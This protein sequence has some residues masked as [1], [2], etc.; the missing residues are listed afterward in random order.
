M[1]LPIEKLIVA[2]NVN[3]ILHRCLAN[4][5]YRKQDLVPTISPS[6]DIMVSSN[7]E[8][9]LFDLHDRDSGKINNLMD[10]FAQ[11]GM[12]LEAPAMKH[13]R[14]IFTSCRVDDQ[15]TLAQVASTY[16]DSAYL[17]D[18]H[19][20]IGVAAAN[21]LKLNAAT[22]MVCLATAHPAKFADAVKQAIPEAAIDLPAHLA[23]LHELEER[24]EVIDSSLTSLHQ[25]MLQK[26]V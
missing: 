7:F 9:L 1:G 4:N 21:G 24:Y 23:N 5:D 18:P 2:T 20:A 14:S 3:D 6:M 8:R 22:P 15:E 13:M 25:A 17:L 12:Q 19:T 10:D 26:L 11:G 16:A